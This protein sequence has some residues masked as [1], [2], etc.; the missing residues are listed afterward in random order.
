MLMNANMVKLLE[1]DLVYKIIDYV[2][3][4][5]YERERQV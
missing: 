1:K 4:Q 2:I 5:K 3:I